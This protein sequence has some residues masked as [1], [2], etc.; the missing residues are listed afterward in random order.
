MSTNATTVPS[1]L[2]PNETAAT[3]RVSRSTVYRMIERGDLAA[4]RL[5]R[6]DGATLRVPADALARILEQQEEER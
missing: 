2:T 4:V 3:L 6:R 1:L 5:G